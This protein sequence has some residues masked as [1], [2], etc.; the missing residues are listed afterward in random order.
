MD[1]VQGTPEW[2]Q[3]RLGKVTASRIADVMAKTKSGPSASRVNYAADL[4][5]ERMTGRQTEFFVNGAMM[6]GTELEPLAREC[7]SFVTGHSVSEIAFIDHPRITMAGCSP[8]GLVNDDGMVEIKCCNAAKHLDLLDG[9]EPDG[10]YVKQTLWQMACTGRAWA[11]L[12]FYNPD[13]PADLQ[14]CIIRIARDDKAIAE[15]EAEVIAFLDEIDA[16]IERIT[17]KYRKA[18]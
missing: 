16:R 7:Y 9:G 15:M 1:I 12:T 2:H 10:R 11:D 14:L 17:T 18:A 5:A 13:L 6:R 4:I 3:I 8:D